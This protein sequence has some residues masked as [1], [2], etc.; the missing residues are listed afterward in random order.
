[1]VGYRG[2]SPGPK[3]SGRTKE[4]WVAYSPF[5]ELRDVPGVHIVSQDDLTQRFPRIETQTTHCFGVIAGVKEYMFNGEVLRLRELPSHTPLEEGWMIAYIAGKVEKVF[6]FARR[7][8]LP[9][10][11]ERVRDTANHLDQKL[12]F[13]PQENA[14]DEYL[15]LPGSD[16][17]PDMGHRHSRKRGRRRF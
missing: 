8:D 16:V 9:C 15:D 10:D 2:G 13:H 3:Y 6:D 7:F 14:L 4:F 1:M 17:L 11:E 12:F 5:D